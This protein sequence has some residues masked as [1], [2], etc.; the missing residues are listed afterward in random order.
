M[1]GVQT[2]LFRSTA[3][4]I[5]TEEESESTETMKDPKL[6]QPASKFGLVRFD[7][8]GLAVWI[9]DKDLDAS[10]M[11]VLHRTAPVGTII[12]V[13]NPITNRSAF[14][15]VVGKFTENETTKDVI[16]VMTK[17]VA[18]AIGSLDKRFF[19]NLNY[20]A[21]ENEQQ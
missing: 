11:F 17:A 19:C 9:D 15:K 10:K 1:T 12:R 20:G 18:D 7:E 6:K 13:T 2:V 3:I 16:I 8:K 21:V 5:G 4:N 14:A